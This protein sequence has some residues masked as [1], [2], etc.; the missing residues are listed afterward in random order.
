MNSSAQ[1]TIGTVS[2]YVIPADAPEGDGTF[3]WDSTTLVLVEL[4]CG[5]VIGLGYTY[6]HK[7][8]ALLA[9][10]LID[11][12]VARSDPFDTNAIFTKMRHE[13]RNYGREGVAATALSAVDVALWDLKAKMMGQPLVRVLG[14][15]RDSAP[16]YGSGG[17]TTYT[18]AQLQ[19][20]LSGW[21]EQGIPRVKMKIGTHPE[22]DLRRVAV[23]R[24]SIGDDAE[25]FVDANG[26][27]SCK[28][29][30]AFA[31][32]F[33]EDD[34]VTWFEEPVSSDDLAG[35]HMLRT[36]GPAGMDIAAGEY[37][38]TA[39][40]LQRMLE[41][42]AVD[43]LQADAM[44]CGGVTGFMD[45]AALCD[46]HPLPMS[47]HCAPTLHTHLA[48]AARPLRHVEYFHDHVRI[49]R[50]FF[51]GFREP[52]DGAL[53]PDLSRPGLGIDF[54]HRDAEKFRVDI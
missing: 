30:L 18:D 26:A 48:C 1:I 47:A 40:Y 29:A 34:R 46:A 6:S 5:D 41:A 43:I 2:A 9:R 23:A 14:Q 39:M 51:D 28:Q 20:Q 15:M 21:V 36:A 33:S 35:L 12:A 54:K 10:D 44:R 31:K 17:F 22:E 37:G 24:E 11:T 38:F 32:K 50:M 45:V 42:Q 13:Q 25:L 8:A 19:Q 49:E 7:A 3:S 27:Y 53:H 52:L 16:V 4:K